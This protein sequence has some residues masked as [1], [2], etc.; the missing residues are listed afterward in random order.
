M[1]NT[2]QAPRRELSFS[3]LGDLK[4]ELDRLDAAHA[5]GN[6]GHTGNWTPGEIMDHLSK[7]WACSL[8]GFP[9]GKPPLMLRMVAQTLLKKKA[10][11]FGS[12]PPPGFKIPKGVDHFSPEPGIAYEK[13]SERLR[14]CISRVE[15]GEQHVPESPLFGK[16]TNDQWINI[17]LGHCAMHLSFLTFGNAG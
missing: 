9:P 7:F 17:H 6:L 15:S 1:I 10:T 14:N 16:L 5:A 11:S 12:Q 2:K 3:S 13:A 8:D 4:A